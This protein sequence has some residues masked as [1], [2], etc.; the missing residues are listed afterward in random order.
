MDVLDIDELK[1]NPALRAKIEQLGV[2]KKIKQDDVILRED[3]YINVIPILLQGSLKIT[4]QDAEGKD[5]DKLV[6]DL[7]QQ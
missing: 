6:N 4:R 1:K 2:I 7:L 5:L 3:A